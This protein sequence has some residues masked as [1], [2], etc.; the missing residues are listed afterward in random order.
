MEEA[1]QELL[2]EELEP[3][4]E[5][6]PQVD[7]ATQEKQPSTELFNPGFEVTSLTKHAAKASKELR[8]ESVNPLD[9]IPQRPS[10]LYRH[11]V[12]SCK[13]IFLLAPPEP[14]Y[15]ETSASEYGDSNNNNDSDNDN[16]T[17]TIISNTE[18]LQGSI[19]RSRYPRHNESTSSLTGFEVTAVPYTEQYAHRATRSKKKKGKAKQKHKHKR[20]K[21]IAGSKPTGQSESGNNP[22]PIPHPEREAPPPPVEISASKPAIAL[23]EV[24]EKVESETRELMGSDSAESKT[25]EL[26]KPPAS[27]QDKDTKNSNEL[28]P[29]LKEVVAEAPANAD[30]KPVNK[31]ELINQDISSTAAPA[32]L[33]DDS[34]NPWDLFI[35]KWEKPRSATQLQEELPEG[36]MIKDTPLVDEPSTIPMSRQMNNQTERR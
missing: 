36:R 33:E 22:P 10:S 8:E 13:S 9:P 27:Q 34:E 30:S 35:N 14:D 2:S 32:S 6:I 21:S 25:S 11:K 12:P 5:A 24:L 19:R 18:L 7:K 3:E 31:P 15:R 29:I 1:R 28:T 26:N 23:P 16:N 4:S 20:K 17:S